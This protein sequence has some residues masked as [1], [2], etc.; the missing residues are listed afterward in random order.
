MKHNNLVPVAR[1]A[2]ILVSPR[3][4]AAPRR[5]PITLWR[6]LFWIKYVIKF[7]SARS[8]QSSLKFCAKGSTELHA[9][10]SIAHKR[11]HAQRRRSSCTLILLGT[12]RIT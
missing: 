4:R 10:V 9:Y 11:H 5:L 2:H 12:F 1:P 3:K 8:A 6:T 7:G